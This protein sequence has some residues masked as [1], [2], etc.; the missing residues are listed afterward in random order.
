VIE[1]VRYVPIITTAFA[2]Y[3][4]YVLYLHWRENPK[5][6]LLWW[7][8]GVA[9]YGLGTL[10]EAATTV[11]GWSPVVFRTWYIAGALLGGAPLAQGTAYLLLKQKSA[12]RISI[13]L[14]GYVA[15]ASAFVLLSPLDLSLVEPH[16]LSGEVLEWQWVRLFSPLANTYAL[17]MLVGGAAWSAWRYRKKTGRSGPRVTGNWLIAVGALLPGIGGSFTRAGMVEVLYV[18]EIVGLSLIFLGYRVI[19]EDRNPSIHFNQQKIMSPQP[20]PA[21]NP[22]GDGR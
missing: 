19:S 7:M 18:T 12:D 5:R 17:I 3:F 16:R 4:T 21:G 10:T 11:A 22:G 6:Y 14:V 2:A 8:I 9:L 1:A 15:M 20:A 13:A